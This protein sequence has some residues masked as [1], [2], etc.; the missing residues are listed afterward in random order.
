MSS[1]GQHSLNC[2]T[3]R[4]PWSGEQQHRYCAWLYDIHACLGPVLWK[5]LQLVIAN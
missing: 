1:F 3:M 4:H 5:A 2:A